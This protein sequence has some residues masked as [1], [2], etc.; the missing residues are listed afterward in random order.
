MK[1]YLCLL[2]PLLLLLTVTPVLS[3]DPVPNM[4]SERTAGNETVNNNAPSYQPH[5]RTKP[6]LCYYPVTPGFCVLR[7]IR[8]AYL[9]TEEKCFS[10]TYSGCAGNRNNFFSERDCMDMCG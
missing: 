10:F 1:L 3:E 5:R 7:F 2:P 4:R 6:P 9:V 8:W